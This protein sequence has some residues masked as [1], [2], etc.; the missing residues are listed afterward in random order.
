MVFHVLNRANDRD[1][2]LEKDEDY[3][4]FLRVLGDTLQKKP[5]RILAYCLMPN[6]GTCFCGP[7]GTTIWVTSCKP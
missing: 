7:N 4:A 6:I 1:E 5:M 2:M 3:L